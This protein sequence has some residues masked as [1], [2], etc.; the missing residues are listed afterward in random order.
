MH[1]LV[2]LRHKRRSYKR[3][4]NNTSFHWTG[5]RTSASCGRSFKADHEGMAGETA[6]PPKVSVKETNK[7]SQ[8]LPLR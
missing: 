7:S 1:V 8:T 5:R 6:S 3:K 2:I 4:R